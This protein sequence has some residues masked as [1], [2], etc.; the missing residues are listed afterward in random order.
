MR[1]LTKLR[2]AGLQIDIDKCE[3][4]VQ[5]TKYLGFIIEAGK[6]IRMDPAKIKAILEWA[7]PTSVKAVQS[8]LGFANFYRRFIKDFSKVAAPLVSLTTREAKE[9]K[10]ILT[11]EARQAFK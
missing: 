5:S 3:F 8:F 10:F 1:V 9:S 11:V 4:S 6:G 7:E 2:E